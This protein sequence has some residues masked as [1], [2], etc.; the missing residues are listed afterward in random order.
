MSQPC[1]V[2]VVVDCASPHK[3]ADWWA[4]TLGWEVE[5]QDEGFIR[6]MIEQ[7]FATDA[8]T[9]SHNGSLVWSSA[10]AIQP[11]AKAS[12]GQP[13]LLFQHVPEPK[14]VKNRIHLDVRAHDG[15]DLD[16]MHR[17]LVQRGATSVGRG[18]QGPHE[19]I[20]YADPEGN[21]FCVDL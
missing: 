19:W 20:T 4:E 17:R 8:E 9:E 15:V 2:Q 21:E 5:G 11:A 3:L 12:A 10:A 13:R 16:V 18:Q 6:S 1:T 7:G 14:T